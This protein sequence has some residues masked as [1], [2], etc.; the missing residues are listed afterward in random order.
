MVRRSLL[1][2]VLILAPHGCA[3]PEGELLDAGASADAAPDAR[4]EDAALA[5]A[6]TLDAGLLDASPEDAASLDAGP[7]DGGDQGPPD[8]QDAS[9]SDD[10]GEDAGEPDAGEPDAGEPDAG[11]PDAGEPDAGI[12]PCGD[13]VL[14]PN[15][16]VCDPGL[17]PCCA[18]DCSGPA[19]STTVCRPAA[20]E[21]DAAELCDGVDLECPADVGLD[22]G[23]ACAGC[24][25]GV[26]CAGCF[27]GACADSPTFCAELLGR[28]VT[29]S[30]VHLV[31]P[32][33]TASVSANTPSVPVYCDMSTAGGGWTMVYKKSRLD[34]RRG[35]ALWTGPAVNEGDLSL[36]GRGFAAV[37]YSNGFQ[38]EYWER[39]GEARIE[40]V[41]GTITQRFIHFDLAGSTPTTWFS[42]TRHT[43]SSWTDLPVSPTWDN[44]AERAFRM[45]GTR[46]FYIN[47]VWSGCANDRGW[48]MVTTN[49][50]CFWE[51][52]ANG[53]TEIIYSRLGT[54]AHIP[55]AAQ[56]GYADSLVILL[57]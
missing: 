4:V 9:A 34:G 17:S 56:T 36:L 41:T 22:G 8:A 16:E 48:M 10:G 30:G 42:P 40:V 24:P 37:D 21:C 7:S 32:A 38:Q 57:R 20:A 25:E 12:A 46:S 2:L 39:F 51:N 6:A 19:P 44:G 33:R 28:G 27:E 47:R 50:T 55:T 5:D 49:T 13:G 31:R 43:S 18:A 3:D 52:T 26:A 15:T 14:D 54:E 11:E 1:A 29:T 23:E 45:A 35:D 53:P